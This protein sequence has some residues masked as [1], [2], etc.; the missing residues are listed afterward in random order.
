MVQD[1]SFDLWLSSHVVPTI[2]SA[3]EQSLTVTDEAPE[4]AGLHEAMRYACLGGGKRIRAALVLAAG[5]AAHPSEQVEQSKK[6]LVAAATAVELIH[7][8]SLVHD[9]MPCMD[10]DE[11]RR[12]KPT[13]HIQYGEA[14]ALLVGD[15]LQSLAFETIAN[16]PVAP[17]L[18]VKAMQHLAVA[19]GSRGMVGGQYMD[20]AS[21]DQQ[22]SKSRLKLMHQLKTG[23]LIQA[24]VLLGS[25][26]VATSYEDHLSLKTY[27]EKLGLAYQVVD[28]ILDATEDTSV[29]G[30]TAGKDELDNKPTYVS[31]LGLEEAKAYADALHQQALEAIQTLGPRADRLR[32]LAALI[33]RR[34]S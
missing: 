8:Y 2:E 34:Q 27:A 9:D 33:V 6:A 7:A 15:A 26:T 5:E 25:I 20:L 21:V 24:S 4:L 31:V 18:V 19:S 14:N 3:L 28:D 23:A 12:G 30:K 16:M 10:D 11:L 29:L 22:I 32:S 13:V 1:P 17:A